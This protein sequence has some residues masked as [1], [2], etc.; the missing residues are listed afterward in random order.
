METL[1]APP[2]RARQPA[3]RRAR[4]PDLDAL[5][6]R[7]LCRSATPRSYAKSR[8]APELARSGRPQ[9]VQADGLQ[10]R[11]R[12]RAPAYRSRR[13]AQIRGMWEQVESIGYNLHPPLL[14]AMGMKKKL[15]L[16]GW[17]RGPLR[18][19]AAI[20]RTARHAVRRFRLR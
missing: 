13:E 17:F 8:A 1:I 18:M 7:R 11:V 4:V 15:K 3:A 16:G 10:R 2:V 14:R 9:S 5:S 6:E 12:S 19:L 20:K